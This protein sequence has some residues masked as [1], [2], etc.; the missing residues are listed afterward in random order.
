MGITSILAAV[1]LIG[2][3]VFIH[4]FGHFIVAKFCG[5]HCTVFSIGYGKRL[6][7]FV[8]RGTDYRISMLPFGGYVRMAGADPFGYGDEDD[9]MLQNPNDA[10]MRKPVWKRLLIVAA[11][12]VFNLVLPIVAFTILLMAGKPQPGPTVGDVVWDSPAAQA[13][14][15]PGDEIVEVD[16]APTPTWRKF[17]DKLDSLGSGSY[18]FVVNRDSEEKQFTVV[19]EEDSWIG[20]GF[21][22]V[23]NQIGV[24]D[25]ASPAAKAGLQTSDKVTA[26]NGQE[27]ASFFEMQKAFLKVEGDT[28]SVSY[29]R[30]GNHLSA[31][32]TAD[33][34]W[35]PIEPNVVGLD[36]RWGILP[37]TLFITE[38]SQT[39]P[40]SSSF[41][42]CASKPPEQTPAMVNGI[43]V[44]DRF[45]K[46][47][48]KEVRH[49]GDILTFV[50]SAMS[51]E[52]ELASARPITVE[53]VRAGELLSL[54]ITPKVIKDTDQM[55]RY[56]YRPLLGVTRGGGYNAGPQVREYYAFGDAFSQSVSHTVLISGFIV[57]Q[58][59]KL[60]TGQ[61]AVEKSLGGP[62]EIARQA[63]AAADEGLFKWFELMA[64]LS[65]SLGII[66]L[67]PIP[68]LDGG[69]L[70]FYILEWIRGKPLSVRFREFTLQLGVIFLVLLM[71]V[72][73]F[74]DIS[75]LIGG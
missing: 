19:S 26:V 34:S 55:G 28:L 2:F 10:F 22:P 7:G 4:E 43:Q 33:P 67:V 35:E 51:G 37:G 68:V 24:Q 41:M 54:D 23:S 8:Y 56:R 64:L 50:G 42:G 20:L 14:L 30:D 5:V 69:Q 29:T 40:K 63:K 44:G 45:L 18:T 16:G 47:D 72:V 57:E 48:G 66:N 71:L 11:G 13:G 6:F 75:R 17:V 38:V 25:P 3:L 73:L 1:V 52:G 12:P 74:F 65:L 39:L 53:I 21:N 60:F 61:A 15:L 59:G 9:E 32:L 62:V 36:K 58:L 27:V 46:I 31:V 49:W 70:V